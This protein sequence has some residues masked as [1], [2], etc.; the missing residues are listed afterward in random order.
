MTKR[1]KPVRIDTEAECRAARRRVEELADAPIGADDPRG[2][3][4]DELLRALEAY[5]KS[6]T[7]WGANGGEPGNGYDPR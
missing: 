4:L 2:E 6:A 5:E 7:R 3:E 1:A